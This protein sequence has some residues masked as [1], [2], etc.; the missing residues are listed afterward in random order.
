MGDGRM[1]YW[2]GYGAARDGK[3]ESDNPHEFGGPAYDAWANGWQAGGSEVMQEPKA[4]VVSKSFWA[5]VVVTIMSVLSYFQDI[6]T[7]HPELDSGDPA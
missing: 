7:A 5:G 1:E 2:A 4:I 6:A 3:P